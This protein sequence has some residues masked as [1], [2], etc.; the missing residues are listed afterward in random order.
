MGRVPDAFSDSKVIVGNSVEGIVRSEFLPFNKLGV[1]VPMGSQQGG[2]G[3][4]V[5]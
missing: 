5:S 4:G 2:G 3:S 1:H